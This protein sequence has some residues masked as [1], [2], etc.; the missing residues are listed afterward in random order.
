MN[1]SSS[2]RSV[3]R[4]SHRHYTI[5]VRNPDGVSQGV[6]ALSVDG[7]AVAEGWISLID[8]GATHTVTILLGAAIDQHGQQPTPM[9]IR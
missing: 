9:R 7:L 6:R 2:E 5:D 4:R 3:S 1:V 8:D